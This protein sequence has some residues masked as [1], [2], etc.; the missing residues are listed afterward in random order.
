MVI[1]ANPLD[2]K[3]L[4]TD[5]RLVTSQIMLVFD[6][7]IIDI[8]MNFANLNINKENREIAM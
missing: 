1:V 5:I 2:K 8:G 4:N 6:P 7:K 3:Y